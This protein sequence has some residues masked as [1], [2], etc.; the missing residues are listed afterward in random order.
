M[1]AAQE[2]TAAGAS[3]FAFLSH[4]ARSQHK[5]RFSHQMS[6]RTKKADERPPGQRNGSPLPGTGSH[7]AP[8]PACAFV[9][10][11]RGHAKALGPWPLK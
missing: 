8:W 3:L 7:V 1:H 4:I 10:A 9:R 6:V 11:V 2:T 5:R